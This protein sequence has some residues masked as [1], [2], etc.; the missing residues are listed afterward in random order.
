MSGFFDGINDVLN[1][2][3]DTAIDD[4]G[5]TNGV[6][7]SVWI[8]P[9]GAGE[10]NG[11]RIYQ[12]GNG[13]TTVAPGTIFRIGANQILRLVIDTT[14]TSIAR[15]SNNNAWTVNTWTHVAYTWTGAVDSTT[16]GF[17]ANGTETTYQNTAS[18][19]GS[20]SSEAALNLWIGNDDTGARSYPGLMAYF[21]LFNRVLIR[22]EIRQ[23]MRFPGSLPN[24]LVAFYPMHGTS[25]G[26]DISPVG[27]SQATITGVF[28]HLN[29]PP[30]SGLLVVPH[31]ITYVFITGG[32]TVSLSESLTTS[33]TRTLLFNSKK[34]D[35]AIVQDILSKTNFMP[36]AELT[37]MRDQMNLIPEKRPSETLSIVESIAKRMELAKSDLV[38]VVDILS[39]SSQLT[40]SEIFSLLDTA[41]KLAGANPNESFSLSEG[42][43]FS[44]LANKNESLS[45]TD[46]IDASIRISVIL[47][48]SLVLVTTITKLFGKNVSETLSFND[49]IATEILAQ[50]LF[51][52]LAESL[53]LIEVITKLIGK[54]S[55]ESF[56][57][58]DQSLFTMSKQV[59]ELLTL[60]ETLIRTSEST[61][62]E[63]PIFADTLTK[64]IGKTASESLTVADTV[65]VQLQAIILLLSL[66]ETLLLTTTLANRL[67]KTFSDSLT[68]LDT[69]TVE[70]PAVVI[71][72]VR[73]IL[74]LTEALERSRLTG[75][76]LFES[77]FTGQL[78]D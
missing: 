50:A 64:L 56:Q 51:L 35:A 11:G 58:S 37:S 24:G 36:F 71:A 3:T 52:S 5:Q 8:N 25:V 20:V 40:K 46:L 73:L 42:R 68:L 76:Q 1:C 77:H 7:C 65:S 17:Y 47:N 63:T 55:L 38:Q 4:L 49:V 13:Q 48:E 45:F 12:K 61:F 9:S 57:I 43:L 66:T 28:T 15:E 44:Y 54:S 75:E 26:R 27:R 34:D 60:A 6:T 41:T 29:E 22:E 53:A 39:Q 32:L 74:L 14:G 21:Q 70:I 18:A 67:D 2:G 31:P 30:I 78:I 23:T 19:T 33:D 10:S 62:T 72:A 16:V 69:I 59:T